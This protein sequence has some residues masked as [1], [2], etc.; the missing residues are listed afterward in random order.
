MAF[1]LAPSVKPTPRR[2]Y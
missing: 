1:D 2:L